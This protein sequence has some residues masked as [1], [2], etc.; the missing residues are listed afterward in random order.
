MN[1]LR[2]LALG[3]LL[4]A[5]CQPTAAPLGPPPP[6]P[7]G[8][9]KATPADP[10]AE[11][12]AGPAPAPVV[13]KRATLPQARKGVVTRIAQRGD[14]KEPADDPPPRVFEKVLYDAPPGKLVAY[15][16]PDPRDFDRHPAVVWIT[17]GDCN[18][19]GNVWGEAPAANDQTAAAYRKAGIVM[20]FPSLRGGNDNP[21][22]KEGFLG[23]VDDVLA[24]ADFL[25][26]QPYVDP[27]RIY[28]GGHS[29]GGTLVLLVAEC[30]ARFRA[31]FSF[32]PVAD[33]RSY[34][35]KYCP[36]DQ[37]NPREV[38]V[39]SPGRWLHEIRSPTFVFEGAAGRGNV[40][41]LRA[42]A[43]ASTNPRARFFPVRGADHFTLLA[44]LNRLIATRILADD[45]PSC[46]LRFTED[47]VNQAV[48]K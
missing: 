44:P 1:R 12:S 15:L 10:P 32:G 24:A 14:L 25:A 38:E 33:V 35:A 22:M 43:R 30:S 27:N 26:Q 16:T 7:G 20:M 36:F 18:S 8:G 17:G 5:G 47:E 11:P 3:L 6:I 45:G 40:D 42:M 23:E 41:D 34:P 21:G 46:N 37:R 39:R 2:A 28:L 31:V 48:G 4:A 9:K 13:Q 29:T 19:I